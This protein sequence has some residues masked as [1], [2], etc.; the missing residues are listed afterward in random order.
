M[1][2]Y[3][4]QRRKVLRSV[5]KLF[6]AKIHVLAFIRQIL[7]KNEWTVTNSIQGTGMKVDYL[8][9]VG[10]HRGIFSRECLEAFNIKDAILIEPNP[11]LYDYLVKQLAPKFPNLN[12]Y[13]FAAGRQSGESELNISA[14]D[15]LSSSILKMTKL[16]LN[17]APDSNYIL[18][19]D[20]LV[21]TIDSVLPKKFKN[22]LLKIDVQGL[23]LDVLIGCIEVLKR[24]NV[25]LVE[26]SFDE[27]YESGS[28]ASEVLAFLNNHG[29]IIFQIFPVFLSK[30]GRLLQADLM[31]IRR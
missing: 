13:K 12:I 22:I 26:V 20:V 3:K 19:V 8:I 10:A 25:V 14:N 31:F 5:A 15:G 4:L 9:D 2:K 23:E 28:S 17:N 7:K 1:V 27:L 16:H 29:F 11:I 18:R 6:L 21:K 30:S 24:T